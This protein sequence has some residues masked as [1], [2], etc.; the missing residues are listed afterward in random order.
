M[1]K[2]LIRNILVN[3]FLFIAIF[4]KKNGLS[5]NMIFHWMPFLELTFKDNSDH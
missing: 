3:G 2:I 4:A 5:G 1:L